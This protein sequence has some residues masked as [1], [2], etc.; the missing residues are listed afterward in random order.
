MPASSG[1]RRR[2]GSEG[3]GRRGGQCKA[4]RQM[5]TVQLPEDER[6]RQRR[7][8]SRHQGAG[9]MDERA[10]RAVI[11]RS[12]RSVVVGGRD[13][14]GRGLNPDRG[15]PAEAVQM[16]MA[17]REHELDGKRK[18][19]NARANLRRERNQC[20]GATFCTRQQ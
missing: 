11:I 5:R 12:F 19:R 6:Q 7:R 16:H 1:E 3:G 10:G 17:E 20:M 2:A 8:R 9:E 4:Q 15:M 13:G 18:E 14:A